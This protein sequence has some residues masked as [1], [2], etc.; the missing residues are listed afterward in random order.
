M[1]TPPCIENINCCLHHNAF[2][3]QQL[4]FTLN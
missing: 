3:G 1:K 4:M 2:D